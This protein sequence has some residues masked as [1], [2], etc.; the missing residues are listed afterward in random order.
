RRISGINDSLLSVGKKCGKGEEAQALVERLKEEVQA[1]QRDV[2]KKRKPS[3]PRVLLVIGGALNE[4]D[5]RSLFIS[6]GDGYFTDLLDLAYAKNVYEGQTIAVPL[7]S[8]EGI[9][10]LAPDLV[11][12]I[13]PP[14]LVEKFPEDTL[15]KAWQ[16]FA[17]LEA[18]EMRQ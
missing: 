13:V 1:I 18:I 9:K 7:L 4:H 17:Q 8:S 11:I 10:A 14:E 16:K 12:E 3:P 5:I 6:G 2:E 15:R